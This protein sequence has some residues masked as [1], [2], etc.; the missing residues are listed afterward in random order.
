ML[1]ATLTHLSWLAKAGVKHGTRRLLGGHAKVNDLTMLGYSRDEMAAPLEVMQQVLDAIAAGIFD[2]DATRSGRWLEGHSLDTVPRRPM[3]RPEGQED[4][5]DDAEEADE[6]VGQVAVQ[7]SGTE[8]AKAA[9][10]DKDKDAREDG[11][12]AAD[13][14]AGKEVHVDADTEA[15]PKDRSKKL[16]LDDAMH[17]SSA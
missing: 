15:D 12:M 2:P 13:K 8:A 16:M 1:A 9:E 7:D 6:E 11:D 4:A 14:N 3:G 10:A 5:A 17:R